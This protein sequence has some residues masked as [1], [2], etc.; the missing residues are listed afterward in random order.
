MKLNTS[1]PVLKILLM[2]GPPSIR[3]DY[4]KISLLLKEYGTNVRMPH[5]KAMGDGLFEMKPK[6]RDG[7]GRVLYCYLKGKKII[8]LHV[9][10]KKTQTTPLK[11]LNVARKRLQEIKNG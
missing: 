10:I 4:R 2:D 11:E 8:I 6:G 5:T 7:I 3:D 1:I 9:F